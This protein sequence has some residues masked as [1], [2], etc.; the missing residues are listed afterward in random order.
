MDDEKI[1]SKLVKLFKSYPQIIAAYFYGSQIE[2]HASSSSDLD[3][4]LIN[5]GSASFDYGDLYLKISEILKKK[6]I[7][8]RIVDKN[9]S[10]VYLFQLFKKGLRV[11]QRDELDRVR[12]E[13]YVL[14]N[15]YDSQHTRDIYKSYLKG[16]FSNGN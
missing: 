2:G 8:L 1:K 13:T 7:D 11:Y 12:F 15:F 6:E 4:A 5:D 9:S 10:P 16:A 3:L 14:I